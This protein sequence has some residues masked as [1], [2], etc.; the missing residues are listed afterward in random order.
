VHLAFVERMLAE[1]GR[2]RVRVRRLLE[3]CDREFFAE[4]WSRTEP[5]LA[6]DARHKN[7]LLVRRGPAPAISAVSPAVAFD[8]VHE[9][10]VIDK[11]QDDTARA[12]PLGITFLPT[13][14]GRPHIVV[15][16]TFGARP[17]V[18]YPATVASGQSAIETYDVVS[19]RLAALS[20]PVRLRLCRSLARAPLTTGE[21]AQ[22][23]RLTA[24]EVSRHLAALTEAGLLTRERQG[25]YVH[26]RLDPAVA[27]RLGTDLL[28]ALLR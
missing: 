12:D 27:G 4:A 21:L 9:R 25:R 8:P 22:Q 24:P 6:A 5:D 28:D 7:D 10:I 2:A 11:L 13:V 16:H 18:Q 1:P 15:M 20:H 3:D 14:F 26:Y 17:V 23:W 19:R